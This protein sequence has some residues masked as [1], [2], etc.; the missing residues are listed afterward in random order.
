MIKKNADIVH[1]D[2][3]CTSK[4]CY[5]CGNDTDK[6]RYVLNQNLN[7]T[8]GILTP[9]TIIMPKYVIMITMQ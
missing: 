5:K 8:P 3:F 1:I 4:K 6:K 7:P 9:G 2:E